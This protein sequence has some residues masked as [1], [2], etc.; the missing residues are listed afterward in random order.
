MDKYSFKIK[1]ITNNISIKNIDINKSINKSIFINNLFE[2]IQN[3]YDP[4]LNIPN[5]IIKD[6]KKIHSI[7]DDS[8]L[9]KFYKL[10]KPDDI[11]SLKDFIDFYIE[12]NL[13]EIDII[14]KNIK[15]NTSLLNKFNEIYF[16]KDD[17][18]E[19]KNIFYNNI[20]V[21]IDILHE[22]ES[23]DLNY[24]EIKKSYF[25]LKLYYYDIDNI[26]E[27]IRNIINIINIIK[28]INDTYNET[29]K[30]YNVI[31]FLGN[32]KKYLF[33]NKIS[34]MN[35]NSGST[36]KDVYVSVWR[37]EEYEKVLIHELCHYI[38]VDFD[39]YLNKKINNDI[40]NL[41]NLEG[42]NHV[43]ESYNETVAG[44]INMCYKSIK[45]NIDLNQIYLIETKFLLFQT[46]KLINFFEGSKGYDIFTM[47][48]YQNTSC[49]SYIILKFILFYNLN[50][51]INLLDEFNLI[52]DSYKKINKLNT[53]LLEIIKKKDYITDIDKNIDFIINNLNNN[54]IYK[55]L[56]MSAI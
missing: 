20:F 56:R 51:F 22:L 25:S 26:D 8:L 36:I 18:Y 45:L 50:D 16:D 9:F 23:F 12:N 3:I 15:D 48:I 54:F 24:I 21:S 29:Q 6:L 49:L 4:N 1:N 42:I 33:G 30:F 11:K 40:N 35:M 37:K 43:S 47:K 13:I 7:D 53:F 27:Y 32:Q 2:I 52:C 41:F 10:Y 28:K 14:K 55:T 31:L 46:I 5:Y 19:I 34:P 38:S 17:R 39:I 44:I